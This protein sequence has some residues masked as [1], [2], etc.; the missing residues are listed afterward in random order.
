MPK[1]LK[2][3]ISGNPGVATTATKTTDILR[4]CKFQMNDTCNR[5][6]RGHRK[7]SSEATTSDCLEAQTKRES[8][9]KKT[10][11]KGKQT[12]QFPSAIK[13]LAQDFAMPG[14]CPKIWCDH[15]KSVKC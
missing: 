5:L 4:K 2:S 8:Q 6:P 12:K 3:A 10:K 14:P 7:Q 15:H 9:D 13:S 1:W 11:T